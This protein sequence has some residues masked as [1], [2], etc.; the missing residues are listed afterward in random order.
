MMKHFQENMK[1]VIIRN[2]RIEHR[3]YIMNEVNFKGIIHDDSCEYSMV[4][5]YRMDKE[6]R[7]GQLLFYDDDG[8]EILDIFQPTQGNL[9]IFSGVH[10]VGE[11]CSTTSK[12]TRSILIF[13]I[14]SED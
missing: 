10:S 9:V 1:S 4:L 12:A 7:G 13:H 8:E 5:Y 6:K 14:N 2:Y 11:L 3:V